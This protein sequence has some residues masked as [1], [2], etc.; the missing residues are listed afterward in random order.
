LQPIV[1]YHGLG[2]SFSHACRSDRRTVDEQRDARRCRLERFSAR[3]TISSAS[4]VRGPSNASHGIGAF[5]GT[6]NFITKHPSQQRGAFA[7]V[8][9]GNDRILDAVARYASGANALD[10]RLTAQHQSDDR[11]A[12]FADRR[13]LDAHGRGAAANQSHRQPDAAGG[14][15]KPG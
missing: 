5:L 6:I 3:W 9:A 15:D 14:C 1:S 10:F 12:N 13:V 4:V 8:N 2:G 11:F 7:N